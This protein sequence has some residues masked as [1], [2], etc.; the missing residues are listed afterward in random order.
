MYTPE[1]CLADWLE[2]MRARSYN[3]SGMSG[4]EY[5]DELQLSHGCEKK[6]KE[7]FSILSIASISP[8]DVP[9]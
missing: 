8:V 6:I 9:P 3:I 2:A 4:R 5:I 7:G 1:S